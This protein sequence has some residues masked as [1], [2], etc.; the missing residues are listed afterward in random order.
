MMLHR[1]SDGGKRRCRTPLYGRRV[2]RHDTPPAE[3]VT[4]K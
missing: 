2:M 4:Y 1:R 3:A